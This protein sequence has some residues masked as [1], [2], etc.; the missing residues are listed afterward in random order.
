[1]VEEDVDVD[2]DVPRDE[3]VGGEDVAEDDDDDGA[4]DQAE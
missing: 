4:M 3:G 1:M 2:V